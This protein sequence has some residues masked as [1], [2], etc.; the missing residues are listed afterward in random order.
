MYYLFPHFFASHRGMRQKRPHSFILEH[1]HPPNKYIL[2]KPNSINSSWPPVRVYKAKESSNTLL[3]TNSYGTRMWLHYS[4]DEALIFSNKAK[5]LIKEI[6]GL[7]GRSGWGGIFEF[8][9][10]KL[11]SSKIILHRINFTL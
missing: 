3:S 10:G 1:S 2:G 5:C 11:L 6:A 4:L 9:H 8:P 7:Y